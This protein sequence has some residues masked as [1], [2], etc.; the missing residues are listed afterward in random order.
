MIGQWHDPLTFAFIIILYI[1]IHCAYHMWRAER[2]RKGLD[3]YHTAKQK[4]TYYIN[5]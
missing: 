2:V 1:I 5:E 3:A 4:R